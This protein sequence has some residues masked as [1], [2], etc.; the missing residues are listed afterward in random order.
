MGINGIFLQKG[1][2]PMMSNI[3]YRGDFIMMTKNAGSQ[4]EIELVMLEQLV[5]P[6]HLLRKIDKHIDFSFIYD[7]VGPYYSEDYGR[8]SLDPIVLFKMSL[9]QAL[10]GIRSERR[11]MDEIHHNMAYRWF[12]GF[13]LTQKIPNHSVFS[14]N[15]ERRFKNTS[16][17]EEI[18]NEIVLKAIELGLVKGEIF[19][20]DSTH[21][22]ASASNSKYENQEVE[23]IITP[24]ESLLELI[25]QKRQSKGQKQLKSA[26]DKI[27]VKNKK[28][29]KTDPDS[30]FMHRDRKPT[31]FY[32]L[33]H[34]T[35]DGANNIILNAHLTPGNV[36][37]SKPY[38]DNLNHIFDT[39]EIIPTYAG[40]DAG[41]FNIEILEELSSQNLIPVIGPRRYSGKKG[42]KSKYWF[43]F[44]SEQDCYYCQQGY[45]LEYSTITRQGY[46]EYKSDSAICKDC[47]MREKCLYESQVDG[48]IKEDQ[49]RIIRRHIKE[50]YA[51]ETRAFMKT[52][53]GKSLYKRRKETIERIF[54]DGKELYGLR[55]AHYRSHANVESQVLITATAMNIKKMAT[56]LNR[57][58]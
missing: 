4:Q 26:E 53:L 51:D 29:S 56:I 8:P 34:M 16:V 46:M 35:V 6:N 39:F 1:I 7:I 20:T 54:A 21:I 5:K 40:A 9:L 58:E 33:A 37:D 27:M 43:T 31:G 11:L 30:G 47:P 22:R 18:F 36:H 19:Y 14:K 41:Y 12:L 52:D 57:L 13:G 50:N 2:A 32:Y 42:K 24:D 38:I 44:D 17:Y 48:E 10:Y 15:R 49:I 55:Y 28:I 45:K 3:I 25:N 23:Q